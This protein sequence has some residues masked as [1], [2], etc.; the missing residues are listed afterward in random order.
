[1]IRSVL[2]RPLCVLAFL[3]LA[4][5]SGGGAKPIPASVGPHSCPAF[6]GGTVSDPMTDP[7]A[8]A[9]GVSSTIG[10]VR[11]PA[12]TGLAGL[13]LYLEPVLNGAGLPFSVQGGTFV[14]GA[15]GALTATIP[16]LSAGQMYA[17]QA[18]VI[19]GTGPLDCPLWEAFFLG[20]FTTQ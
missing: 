16:P 17:A 2:R 9:T 5:C 11:V 8:G 15:P 10:H 13:T 18:S 7:A 1:M 19:V 4:A 14:A 3:A 12:V 6:G 20:S